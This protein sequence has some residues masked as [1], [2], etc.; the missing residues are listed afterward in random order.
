MNYGNPFLS[1]WMSA[2]NAWAGTAR[3]FWLGEWQRQQSAMVEEAIRQ[4]VD[5]W[6]GGW[7]RHVGRY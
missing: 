3:S 4:A 6:T 7:M 1:A 2:A 5:F